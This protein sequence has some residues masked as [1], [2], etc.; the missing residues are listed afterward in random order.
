MFEQVDPTRDPVV[1]HWKKPQEMFLN[2]LP[3][4]DSLYDLTANSEIKEVIDE[5]HELEN[6]QQATSLQEFFQ[7]VH[8]GTAVRPPSNTLGDRLDIFEE[9]KISNCFPRG[10]SFKGEAL[11]LAA[12]QQNLEAVQE[13]LEE[14]VDINYRN[15]DGDTALHLASYNGDEE[16]V[17]LLLKARDFLPLSFIFLSISLVSLSRMEQTHLQSMSTT[18]RWSADPLANFTIEGIRYNQPAPCPSKQRRERIRKLLVA[19]GAR[20]GVHNLWGWTEKIE[21]RRLMETWDKYVHK[22]PLDLLQMSI[23]FGMVPLHKVAYRFP[24]DVVGAVWMLASPPD[25]AAV[26]ENELVEEQARKMGMNFSIPPGDEVQM[27]TIHEQEQSLQRGSHVP[28]VNEMLDRL[29]EL[30]F[31]NS[32]EDPDSTS[33]GPSASLEVY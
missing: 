31:A 32:T 22:M 20:E 5:L 25:A 29:D 2:P 27:G 13:L 15:V 30:S 14:G 1:E 9:G 7:C 28:N 18:R 26:T 12:K 19:A 33:D 10:F 3:G 17:E 4:Q 6:A 16:I 23:D 21:K 8:N 11:S 24:K